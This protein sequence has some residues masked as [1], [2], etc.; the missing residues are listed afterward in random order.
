MDE[1]LD[2]TRDLVESSWGEFAR[3]D[4]E[5]KS[6]EA[7]RR[8][9]P[10][11][12]TPI[13]VE[14]SAEGRDS[15]AL[16]RRVTGLI[17]LIFGHGPLSVIAVLVAVIL[18]M[19]GVFVVF[20][21]DDDGADEV[22]TAGATVDGN[23]ATVVDDPVDPGAIP[24]GTYQGVFTEDIGPVGRVFQEDPTETGRTETANEV[25]LVVAEDGAV[26]GTLQWDGEQ[27][28]ANATCT[29]VRLSSHSGTF[30]GAADER[31]EVEGT[32]SMASS[33]SSQSTCSGEVSEP[34]TYDDPAESFPFTATIVDGR[35]EG[36][37]TGI[38]T[39]TADL[40]G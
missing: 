17:D 1:P 32:A 28:S 20:G 13:R 29:T 33:G 25:T 10:D 11:D 23:D 21:G 8:V 35:A 34:V 5:R 22:D 36:E 4:A 6:R 27:R 3:D 39:F 12:E 24:A 26:T 40:V 16:V 9:E 18:L 37:I 19:F 38:F 7:Q 31:G 14:R 2:E 15:S 30:E